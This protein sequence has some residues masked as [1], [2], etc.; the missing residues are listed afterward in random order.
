M[1]APLRPIRFNSP[2]VTL[3]RRRDGS[4]LVDPVAALSSVPR[5][6]TDRLVHWATATPDRTFVAERSSADGGWVKVS[7]AEALGR[8]RAIGEALVRRGLS[9]NRP[10]AIL[11]G[12]SVEHLMLA[13]GALH[14]GIPHC[15]IS[16]P[17]SLVSK[18]FG[19]LRHAMT[20]LTPGLVYADDGTPF[21]AA[22][23]AAIPYGT[24]LVVGSNPPS[25]RPATAYSDLVATVPGDTIDLANSGIGP[26]D[27][28]KFLLTSGSTGLPKAVITTQ[29][30]LAANQ[31]Q[32]RDVLAFLQDE[33]P[34][35]LDWLPWNHVFGG[36]HNVGLV[37]FN[38]G[39]LYIDGGRPLPGAGIA[40]TVRNLLD[41]PPTVYFNV[42]KGFEMLV[43]YLE[44]D[45]R[46]RE[47]FFSR[48]QCYFFAGAGLSSH[49]WQALDALAVRSTG[50]RLPMLTGLGATE[51]AP[52]ALSATPESSRSGM[53]GLPVPGVRLKLTPVDGKLEARLRGPNIT[54]GYW[55]NAELT[56]AA[57]DDEGYY[58]LGDA[59]RF[60]DP[61]EVA[62]G[63]LFD[64]RIA[65]DFKLSS[66]TWVS[67]GPLRAALIAAC[68]PL[69]RDVVIAAPD[70]DEICAMIFLEADGCRQFGDAAG[71]R[72]A[73][74]IRLRNFAKGAT[75][76]S[77]RLARAL[78]LE[79]PPSIDLGEVTDKGSI[80]QR[81][82]LAHRAN[83]VEALYA[84]PAPDFVIRV[85]G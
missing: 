27:I 19:K 20:L 30:M 5:T 48:L 79:A 17:Y 72:A 36:S 61:N 60:D 40:T 12:N 18:D 6:L 46:L 85:D 8:V 7:Y 28:A 35:I 29:F 69:V 73:L 31:V 43:P 32:L 34:V 68:A 82:V 1:N 15:A 2:R 11:S 62:R 64:G 71:T 4:L 16:P 38:G 13:L 81:A 21:A 22:I 39:T 45:D 37:L 70:R 63:F 25:D 47:K 80:N 14:A 77:T 10:V 66:G 55:R 51:S 3:E 53:V 74:E 58:R 9:A 23:N 41:V 33:P 78:V 84:N 76:S 54:P 57:F 44:A 52:F 24:E 50:M 42:P 59:L 26:G 83:L 65:E 49:V 56:A 67:V 75:G